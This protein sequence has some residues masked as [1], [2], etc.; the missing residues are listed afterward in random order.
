MYTWQF[1]EKFPLSHPCFPWFVE[2]KFVSGMY[3]NLQELRKMKFFLGNTWAWKQWLSL[4]KLLLMWIPPIKMSKRRKNT[5][6]NSKLNLVS[7]E[8]KQVS[9]YIGILLIIEQWAISSE[10]NVGS[11]FFFF[12]TNFYNIS[13]SLQ[14]PYCECLPLFLSWAVSLTMISYKVAYK[15]IFCFSIVKI[16]S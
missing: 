14:K 7:E 9:N 11:Y 6:F 16:F 1:Q 2:L 10:K 12:A 4:Q 13:A 5:S 8:V 15:F 3:A